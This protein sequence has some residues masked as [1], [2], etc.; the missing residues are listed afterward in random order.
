MWTVDIAPSVSNS[1][2][3]QLGSRICFSSKFSSK[4]GDDAGLRTILLEPLGYSRYK[5]LDLDGSRVGPE[6]PHL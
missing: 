5:K 4:D 2:G 1:V 6:I 3:L